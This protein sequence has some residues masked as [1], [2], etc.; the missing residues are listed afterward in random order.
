MQIYFDEAGRW[1]LFWPLFI[2]L[3]VSS[4][5]K[6]ALARYELFQDSKKLTAQKRQL[7][8]REIKTLEEK[9]QLFTAV[10]S[11]S[12]EII[13]RYGVT[14]AVNLAVCKGLYQLLCARL[15]QEPAPSFR[16]SDLQMLIKS[17]ETQHQKKIKLI[18]DGKSDFWLWKELGIQTRTII[19]GD[20]TLKE[21]SI[22]SLLAKVRRDALLD[23]FAEKYPG[24]SFEKHK[25]Y[26]TKAH[27]AAIEQQGILKEHRKL[28]LKEFF[29]DRKIENFDMNLPVVLP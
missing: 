11:V 2:G 14:R 23:E 20:A 3:V 6:K 24:Y 27:Y 19:H 16:L 22:A 4:L 15:H 9:G 25:G 26:G 29:P 12:S 18:L 28:F 10:A 8:F 13:D 7:A 17:Y 1:P 21:I 5:S